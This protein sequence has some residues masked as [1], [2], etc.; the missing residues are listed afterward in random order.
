MTMNELDNGRKTITKNIKQIDKLEK[1]FRFD[2][3]EQL[4]RIHRYA[5][6][7]LPQEKTRY[8]LELE[9]YKKENELRELKG[10]EPLPQIKIVDLL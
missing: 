8:Q 1:W 9:A 3:P 10:L 6:L 7:G 4:N 2:Y 5:Y